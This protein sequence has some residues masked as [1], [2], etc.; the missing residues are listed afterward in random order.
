MKNLIQIYLK[1]L[2]NINRIIEK[3]DENFVEKFDKKEL[4]L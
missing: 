4:N 2:K 1:N 3:I